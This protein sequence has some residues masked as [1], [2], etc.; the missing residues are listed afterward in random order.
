VFNFP[1]GDTIINLPEFGSK[2]PYYDVLRSAQFNG[3]REKL[4]ADYPILVHPMDKTDNYIKRCVAIPGDLLEIKNGVLWINQAPAVVTSAAQNEYMVTTNGQYFTEEF[5][6]D[7]L[8]ISTTEASA[9]FSL[10]EGATNTYRINMTASAAESVRRLPQVISVQL[11]VDQNIG[12][13]FP[14]DVVHAP[15]TI[16]HYGPIRIPKKG[17]QVALND[18]TIEI[19]RRLITAYEH[20]TLEKVNG[21]YMLNGK[22]ANTYTVQQDYY[23]MMGDNRHRSQ[24]SRFWGFVP[25]NHIVGKPVFIWLSVDP[26]GRGLN[27]IRWERVF[28]TV[29]GE[30]EPYSYLKFF[31]LGLAA[32]FG[33]SYLINKKKQNS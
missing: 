26:N 7:S 21:Q 6:N 14:N 29:N 4:Q 12:Y 2:I 17:D 3:D 11:F 10:V 16:D 5:I 18:A 9:D 33:I 30:G 13:T 22:V 28:T 1:A 15:W 24:D 23:W 27:K 31:L 20:N 8:G 25:E 19:Y 32:Y